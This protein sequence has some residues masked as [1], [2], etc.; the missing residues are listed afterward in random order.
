LYVRQKLRGKYKLPDLGVEGVDR[1]DDDD[2]DDNNN[3]FN[4]TE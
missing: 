4:S 3:N 2:D 1:D